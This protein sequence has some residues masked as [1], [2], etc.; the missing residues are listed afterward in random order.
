MECR[1]PGMSSAWY[2]PALSL[3]FP[4]CFHKF[5]FDFQPQRAARLPDQVAHRAPG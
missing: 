4:Q 2:V 3:L 5:L 1:Q